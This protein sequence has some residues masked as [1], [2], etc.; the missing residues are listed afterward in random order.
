MCIGGF[1][2]LNFDSVSMNMKSELLYPLEG[3]GKVLHCGRKN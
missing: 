2:C 3:K 1:I